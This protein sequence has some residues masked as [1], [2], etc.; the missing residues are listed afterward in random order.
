MRTLVL[1]LLIAGCLKVQPW[2]REDQAR[3]AMTA[4]FGDDD[5]AGKDRAKTLESKNGG[6][7]AWIVPGGG[8]GCTQ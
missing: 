4:H 5:L 7:A 2:Q 6:G 3:R 1:L 8:C